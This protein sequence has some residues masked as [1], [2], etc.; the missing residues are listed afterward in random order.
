[1]AVSVSSAWIKHAKRWEEEEEEEGCVEGEQV[2]VCLFL[3]RHAAPDGMTYAQMAC[4]H[5]ALNV[6]ARKPNQK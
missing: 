5:T 3:F 6:C 2:T 1:M 4:M